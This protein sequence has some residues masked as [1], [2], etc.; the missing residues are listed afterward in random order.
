VDTPP[1]KAEE[2]RLSY[3]F[4]AILEDEKTQNELNQRM[5]RPGEPG[6]RAPANNSAVSQRN[7]EDG[8]ADGRTGSKGT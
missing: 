4:D 8:H 3:T 7:E 5:R 6:Y 1:K 2:P